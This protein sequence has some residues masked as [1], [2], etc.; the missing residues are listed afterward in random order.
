MYIYICVYTYIHGQ[1]TTEMFAQNGILTPT[2]HIILRR[3]SEVALL[4][5]NIQLII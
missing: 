4:Y 3:H 2:M 1:M 5:E